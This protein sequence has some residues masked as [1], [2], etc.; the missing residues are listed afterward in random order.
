MAS[1][2]GV[3]ISVKKEK[4]IKISIGLSLSLQITLG[5]IDIS[6]IPSL[7]IHEHGTCFRISVSSLNSLNS[8]LW[9]SLCKS[10]ASL[11]K[12]I[13]KCFILFFMLF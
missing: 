12:S 1:K 3:P 9:L 10:F 5:N 8:V 11:V 13:P 7:A 4:V 6:T 2:M